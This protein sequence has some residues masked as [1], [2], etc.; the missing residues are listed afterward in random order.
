M[1]KSSPSWINGAE[2]AAPAAGTQ[3]VKVVVT[4]GR[5]G[6]ISG[7]RIVSQEVNAAG[8]GWRVRANIQG[9]SV[10]A[11]DLDVTNPSAISDYPFFTLKGNGFDFFEI[12][13]AVAGTAGTVHQASFLY[14]EEEISPAERYDH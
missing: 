3:L 1:G 11:F 12:V 4:A 6:K 10:I 8:K 5:I 9:T 2:A 14:D 7:A 13:N